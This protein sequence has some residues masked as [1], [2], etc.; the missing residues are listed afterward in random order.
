M[1][2]ESGSVQLVIFTLAGEQYAMPINSVQE[3][4]RYRRPRSVAST[5]PW[6]QGVLSLRGHI[7]PVYDLADRLGT[8][9]SLGEDSKIV[10]LEIAHQVAGVIVDTVDEV[11][12][13]DRE[14][15]E[16]AP[17]ADSAIIDSIAEIENRLVILLNPGPILSSWEPIA[18]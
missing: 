12:T 14:H 1:A 8:T 10:I 6:V 13:I 3:I 11:L 17:A 9:S 16:S 4:I 18:A 15:I 2:D 5:E 7:V